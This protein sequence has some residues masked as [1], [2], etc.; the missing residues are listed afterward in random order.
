M[1]VRILAKVKIE[2]RLSQVEYM[3]KVLDSGTLYVSTRFNVAAHLCPCGCGSKIITPLG[4]CEW[5]FSQENGRPTLDP[6][7]GNWQIPCQS[8][9]WIINGRI[10]WSQAW[11]KEQIQA[12]RIEEQVRRD[13]YYRQKESRGIS[14]F[15]ILKNIFL[16]WV[17]FLCNGKSH[18]D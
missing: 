2:I 7:I 8:H 9:Y 16:K 18:I 14:I 6:S 4:P 5:T 15:K 13:L 11:T 1:I 3:P 10:L 17:T 12:G